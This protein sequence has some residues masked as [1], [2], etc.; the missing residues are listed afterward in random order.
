MASNSAPINC[1]H[2]PGPR[3][4]ALEDYC[5]WQQSQVKSPGLKAEYQKACDAIIEDGLDLEQIHK[6]PNPEFLIKNGV[7]RGIAH[8][9][10]EDIDYW[11]KRYKQTESEDT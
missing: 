1:L 10:V 6:D 4:E 9:V 8:R 5:A 3:D 7:K 2:I 11:V